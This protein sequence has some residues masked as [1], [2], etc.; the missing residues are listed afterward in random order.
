MI[1]K[2]AKSWQ[3]VQMLGDCANCFKENEELKHVFEQKFSAFK[4]LQ[5]YLFISFFCFVTYVK[6]SFAYNL[7]QVVPMY[8][9]TLCWHSQ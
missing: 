9:Y 7:D 8:K 1:T 4:V 6:H 5:Y 2:Y 3:S